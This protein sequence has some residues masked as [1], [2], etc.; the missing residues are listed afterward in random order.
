MPN[1]VP[2]PTI[3][4]LQG[5]IDSSTLELII[6]VSSKYWRTMMNMYMIPKKRMKI[7]TKIETLTI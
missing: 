6:D 7:E 2:I 1:V 3:E 4:R 5:L